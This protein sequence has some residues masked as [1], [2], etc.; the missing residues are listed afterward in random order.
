MKNVLGLS[1]SH[2]GSPDSHASCLPWL[3]APQHPSPHFFHSLSCLWVAAAPAFSRAWAGWENPD[4]TGRCSISRVD[5]KVAGP[6]HGKNARVF[7]Q[8]A[9]TRQR[10]ASP[11]HPDYPA[12]DAFVAISS[13]PRGRLQRVAKSLTW[14]RKQK[15]GQFT[16]S[17]G[18]KSQKGKIN[19]PAFS[20]D[21]GA[22]QWWIR[23]EE[24]LPRWAVH[25]KS[26]AAFV[27]P[28]PNE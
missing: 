12:A 4:G 18:V 16:M 6:R 21:V 8:L 17:W 19:L 25:P 23:G 13:S 28:V 15:Q 27:V 24:A 20:W 11:L 14:L 2:R 3:P 7:F 5:L 26:Q 10:R 9:I 1:L 22:V